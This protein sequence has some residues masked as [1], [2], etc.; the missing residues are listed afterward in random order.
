[1]D[2]RQL[3]AAITVA[4]AGSV[5]KAAEILHVVQPAVTRQVRS[6]E[7]D[8]G[9][10]LFDR[11]PHGMRPTE[12]GRVVIERGRRAL[13][14]LDRARAEIAPVPGQ[15]RGIATVGL[16]SSVSDLL[17]ERLVDR[18]ASDY[19]DVELRLLTAYSGHLRDWLDQGDAD[20]ALLYDIR[21]TPRILTR[22]LIREEL[23][24]VGPPAAGLRVD[25]PVPVESLA[26]EALILPTAGHSLRVLIDEAAAIAG[27]QLTSQVATN[28]LSVQKRLVQ[29]GHGKTILPAVAVATEVAGGSLS[30]APLSNP[31][32]TRDLVL[33]LAR[34]Q[35]IPPAT[36]AVALVLHEEVRA[37]VADGLWPAARLK[38]AR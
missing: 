18:V 3:V 29:A 35:R 12:A 13:A 19:P 33:A 28:T 26:G 34:H 15:V 21:S 10:A 8:L 2:L 17:A 11:T 32:V 25:H 4:E 31:S 24:V 30:G 20:I 6:L 5:T 23:W 9:V 14:E 1:M 16:L 22:P 27:I 37:T 38:Q 7:R 36:E